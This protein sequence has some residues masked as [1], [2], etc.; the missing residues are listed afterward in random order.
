MI[1]DILLP[2]VDGY[3]LAREIRRQY[4]FKIKPVFIAL[5]GIAYDPSH[6]YAQE[7]GFDVYLNKPAD[8]EKITRALHGQRN[9]FSC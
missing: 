9:G 8:L 2:D 3:A 7:A 5:S 6:P 1:L 4:A